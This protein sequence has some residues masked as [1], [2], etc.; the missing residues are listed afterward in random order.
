MASLQAAVSGIGK[1]NTDLASGSSLLRAGVSWQ[2]VSDAQEAAAQAGGCCFKH[3]NARVQEKQTRGSRSRWRWKQ[4]SVCLT[5]RIGGAGLRPRWTELHQSTCK[6]NRSRHFL[7]PVECFWG[8]F[9]F[10]QTGVKTKASKT[11]LKHLTESI[12]RGGGQT[13][14]RGPHVSR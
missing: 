14:V 9:G 10:S 5:V 4:R 1:E 11:T 6:Q 7:H 2:A 8:S 12:A 13:K 3:I